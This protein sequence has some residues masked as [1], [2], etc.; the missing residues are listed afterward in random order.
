M[1]AKYLEVSGRTYYAFEEPDFVGPTQH[2]SESEVLVASSPAL[3]S[4]EKC[5]SKLIKKSGFWRRQFQDRIT[6]GQRKFDWFFG[7][8][9]PSICFFFD[10]IVFTTT[11]NGG[12][13]LTVENA[14]F[15]KIAAVKAPAPRK[16]I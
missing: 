7:V 8:I 13:Q 4:I 3:P 12:C 5:S 10:P 11:M 16:A 9:M 1:N 15:D 6:G 2:R 14:D